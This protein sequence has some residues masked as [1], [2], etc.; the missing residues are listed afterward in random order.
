ME[1]ST[2]RL[3]W[4]LRPITVVLVFQVKLCKFPL[5]VSSKNLSCGVSSSAGLS[6]AVVTTTIIK[7]Y[8]I[9]YMQD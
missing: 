2:F 3:A 5:F 1:I 6:D 7:K 4:K 8:S 9:N